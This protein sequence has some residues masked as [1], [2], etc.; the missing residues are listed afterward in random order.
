MMLLGDP[1]SRS[2]R[3]WAKLLIATIIVVA[4]TAFLIWALAPVHSSRMADWPWILW[5]SI[6]YTWEWGQ[7][8]IDGKGIHDLRQLEWLPFAHGIVTI[9]GFLISATLIAT[10]SALSYMRSDYGDSRYATAHD[11][12]KM[13]LDGK[14]GPVLGQFRRQMLMQSSPRSILVLAPTRAGKTRGLV[15]PTLLTYPGTMV[16]MDPKQE[17]LQKT[18]DAQRA[19]G[20]RVEVLDWANPDSPSGWNPLGADL[21]QNNVDLERALER[22][23]AMIFADKG[24]GE[25]SAYFRDNGRRNYVAFAMFE[26]LEARRQGR[27]PNL[28]DVAGHIGKFQIEEDGEIE[29]DALGTM[30]K[31]IA[32][33]AM[34]H[35]YPER[36]SSDLLVL[37]QQ[38]P[39]PRG[40]HINTFLTGVQLWR[41]LSVRQ[42]TSRSSFRFADLRKEP[43]TVYLPFPQ[44]D[45]KAFG[46]LTAIF[47]ESLFAWTLDHEQQPGEHPILIVGEEWASLPKIP[48]VFDAL[49]KGNGMGLHL[50]I[51]LQD[52]SQFKELYQDTGVDQLFTNCT[53]VVAFNQ[54]KTLEQKRLSETV[55]QTTRRRKSVNKNDE[56]LFG[57]SSMSFEGVPLIRPEQWGQ[58]PFGRHVLLAQ[59]HFTTPIFCK[60]PF[61]DQNPKLRKLMN[62]T[63]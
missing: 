16:V 47:L 19:M 9:S 62:R 52:L 15:I 8:I 53:Y 14:M 7:Y 59:S 43:T 5:S 23:A 10:T 18:A 31:T 21:P 56:K 39:K 58:I 17:L 60:T 12:R 30:L 61:W 28:A 54:P 2:S 22:Q 50:M 13:K 20:R 36:I 51:V 42:V 34:V 46:P 37:A 3:D 11:V 48:L 49:A 38:A 57:S 29:S 41:N 40:E 33:T 25:A 26:V 27:E 32:R 55:G 35:G 63:S 45:A 6:S 44:S 4:L 24:G 1:L